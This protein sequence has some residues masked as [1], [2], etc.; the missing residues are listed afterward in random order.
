MIAPMRDTA[1]VSE[2]DDATELGEVVVDGVSVD[3]PRTSRPR[4]ALRRTLRAVDPWALLAPIALVIVWQLVIE[5]ELVDVQY[6]PEPQEVLSAINSW[7]FGGGESQALYNG[8]W[9]E[10]ALASSQ[11]VIYGFVVGSVA[12]VLLGFVIGWSRL[13]ARIFDPLFQ[14]LRPIPITAWLPFVVV[15]LGTKGAAAVALIAIGAFFP[16]LLNTVAGLRHVDELL[17]RAA[18]MLG[19]QSRLR[20]LYRVGIP[21][22]LPS[23]FTGLRLSVGLSWVL[24]IVAEMIAVK[25]GFGYVMW[26]AYYFLRMD[27]I[28]AAMLSVGVMGFLFDRLVVAIEAR[29]CAWKTNS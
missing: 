13:G 17:M 25:S 16:V 11:R 10:H 26:D 2:S 15:F 23:I 9:G 22:A 27:M 14:I 28:V 20:L 1:Q 19:C 4:A 29:V 8:T 21:A 24:V 18:Q 12:G 5:W 6:L 7:I 3:A